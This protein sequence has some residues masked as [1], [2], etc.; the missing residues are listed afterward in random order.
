MALSHPHGPHSGTGSL[1][2]PAYEHDAC[3]VAFVA[4]LYGRRSHDV[5]AKGLS[6][7]IRLDHRGARGAEPNTGDGAGI[8]LQIPD[9]FLRAAVDFPLP[10]AGH[11]ATGLVFLPS[12][13]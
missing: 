8:M 9:E 12:S 1:Y 7:L 5:V 11:Y 4:D 6:A 10:P 2:D 13:A 3:G